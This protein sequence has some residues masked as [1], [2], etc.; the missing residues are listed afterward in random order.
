MSKKIEAVGSFL[1]VTDTVS[2]VR[3]PQPMPLKDMGW[4]DLALE[5]S[6]PRIVFET[7]MFLSDSTEYELYPPFLLSDAVDLNGDAFTKSSFR[8]FCTSNMGKSSGGSASI[9]TNDIFN[10]GFYDYNDLATTAS[11]ITV[12]TATHTLLTNDGAGAFTN[13]TYK[14][15]GDTDVWDVSINSFDWSELKLGDMIDLRLDFDLTTTS[16]NTEIE[17]DLHLGTGAG[18]YKIPFISELN[19]KAKG[20]YKVNRF[21]GIYLG[22]ANTLDNG[23]QFKIMADKNCTVVV[24]GWY[25]KIIK[26]G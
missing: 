6:T 3:S 19:F 16:T 13:K 1:I 7:N 22:D 9:P 2:G 14:P 8:D 11:P 24:N 10:G 18:A 17:V 4:N 5:E 20:T 23:G 12:T 25:C 15:T 21:N 26:R